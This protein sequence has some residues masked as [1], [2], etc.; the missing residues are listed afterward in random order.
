[1]F[2]IIPSS[3][4]LYIYNICR[5][6]CP[7][8][9]LLKFVTKAEWILASLMWPR[10]AMSRTSD[11]PANKAVTGAQLARR[12]SQGH[13][14]SVSKTA[15]RSVQSKKKLNSPTSCVFQQ[16]RRV[17]AFVSPS[18]QPDKEPLWVQ[19]SDKQWARGSISSGVVN[20]HRHRPTS[21]TPTTYHSPPLT[22]FDHRTWQ[23]HI[24]FRGHQHR[25]AG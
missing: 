17:C 7:R 16:V 11:E 21:H 18:Q 25:I 1:M 20:F 8:H 24:T 5:Q 6:V 15:L 14:K 13:C 4:R 22:C 19:D 23:S 3:A 9:R 2:K 12:L 10:A